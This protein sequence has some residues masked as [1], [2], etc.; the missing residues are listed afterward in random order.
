MRTGRPKKVVQLQAA[1]REKLEMRA[2]RPTT[3]Q[4]V[5]IRSKIIL[6]AAESQS[7]QEIARALGIT[8]A[9]VGQWRER[10]R[11]SGMEGL[12]DEP[13]PGAPRKITDSQVEEAVTGNVRVSVESSGSQVT[14]S[15]LRR[16]ST[17]SNSRV[18]R[19]Q[20]L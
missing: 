4:R 9:T 8:G 16:L 20:G 14:N 17:F 1:D 15:T 13:R 7:N 19:G 3:A 5:A 2:R 11:V 18:S 6:R 10:F 12:S